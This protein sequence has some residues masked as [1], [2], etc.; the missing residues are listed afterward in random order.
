MPLVNC[1][2]NLILTW[3]ADQFISTETGTTKFA[4]TD[5]KLYVLAVTL[6]TEDNTKLLQELRSGFKELIN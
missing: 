1:E 6:T 4:V 5:T 3:S 2:I